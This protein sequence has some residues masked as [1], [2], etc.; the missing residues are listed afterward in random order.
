MSDL[1]LRDASRNW[2][3]T[4][5]FT[6]DYAPLAAELAAGLR[7]LAQPHHLFAVARSG[8]WS[9]QTMRKPRI[10]LDAMAAYPDKALILMDVDCIVRCPLDELPAAAPPADMA[11]YMAVKTKRLGRHRQRA[12]LSSRVMLI[13]PTQGA[14]QLML[15][16][17]E[18]CTERPWMHGDEPN[19]VLALARA[20]GSS[21]SPI[22][23]RYSGREIDGA[24]A[25]AAIVH[26][27]ARGHGSR[28]ERALARLRARLAGAVPGDPMAAAR[29]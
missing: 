21:F 28:L 23:G 3:V 27:S 22:D 5:F 24:P 2:L 26:E 13:R 6:P 15:R 8:D 12:S 10:V 1:V 25:D 14:R 4:G 17:E 18:A 29:R 16:W 11:C 7:I 19:L 9:S 20:V